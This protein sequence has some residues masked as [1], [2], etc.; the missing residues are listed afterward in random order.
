MASYWADTVARMTLHAL[1]QKY[2][3]IAQRLADDRPV[4]RVEILETA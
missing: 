1:A 4:R 3:H 2:A